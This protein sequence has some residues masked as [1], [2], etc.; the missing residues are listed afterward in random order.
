MYGYY[1]GIAFFSAALKKTF[2]LSS[3]SNRDSGF[4]KNFFHGVASSFHT[5]MLPRQ[6]YVR[7]VV[8]SEGRKDNESLKFGDLNW[9]SVGGMSVHLWLG[10]FFD[11]ELV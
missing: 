3:F 4:S 2:Q 9:L 10:N 5:H 6:E 1:L 8:H 11:S 7:G